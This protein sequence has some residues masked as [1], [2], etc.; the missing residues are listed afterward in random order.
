MS[1]YTD[2]DHR[3]I[4]EAHRSL[5]AAEEVKLGTWDGLITDPKFGAGLRLV[6]EWC[7]SDFG[8]TRELTDARTVICTG[9]IRASRVF[10]DEK[11]LR[12][13]LNDVPDDL[14]DSFVFER[15]LREMWKIVPRKS[16]EL[17]PIPPLIPRNSGATLRKSL[18][19]LGWEDPKSDTVVVIATLGASRYTGRRPIRKI[20]YLIIN[21]P[22]K[23]EDLD[24]PN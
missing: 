10:L 4:V 24:S 3:R 14:K 6:R 11:P 2:E 21:P 17:L 13:F 19:D 12:I 7:F 16:A 5:E 22:E 23:P 18:N 9:T 15:L 1:S 8:S 20:D